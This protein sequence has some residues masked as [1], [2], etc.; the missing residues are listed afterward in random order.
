MVI[1]LFCSNSNDPSLLPDGSVLIRELA[2]AENPLEA[3]NCPPQTPL[4]HSICSIHSFIY[5]LTTLG[6]IN[7]NDVRNLSIGKWG[8]ELGAKVLAD[9]CQL[10][11]N[12]IWESSML[13]WL[14]NEEQQQQQ[15]HQLQQFYQMQLQQLSQ[16]S[17]ALC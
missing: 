16:I 13:L 6:K 2:Q 17:K 7:Q 10:Y 11:M 12:L 8:G 3:I 5:L 1:D 9:L 14:C 4:L 15:L